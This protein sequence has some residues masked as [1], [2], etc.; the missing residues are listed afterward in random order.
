MKKIVLTGGPCGG[1][2]TALV[3]IKEHFQDK[4]IRVITIPE[5]VTMLSYNGFDIPQLLHNDILKFEETLL[6]T[7]IAIEDNF[8]ELAKIENSPCIIIFDRGAL[9]LKA[10]LDKNTWEI[11]LSTSRYS[12]VYLRDERYDAVIH[13]TTAA[14]GAEDF[15]TLSNNKARTETPEQARVLDTKIIEAWTGQPHLRIIDNSF[16]FEEKMNRVIKEIEIIL[17]DPHPTEYERKFK[18]KQYNIPENI[19]TTSIEITQIYLQTQDKNTEERIR[20]RGQSQNFTY[21]HTKKIDNRNARTEIERQI[22]PNE[23]LHLLELRDKTIPAIIKTRR[24]FVYKSQ[25][26]ELDIFENLSTELAILEI[27]LENENSVFTIPKFIDIEKE[28]T[29]NKQFKNKEIAK[30]L[31]LDM[32]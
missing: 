28:V 1:K 11:L 30:R 31:A 19:P 5:L 25:Y 13:L 23:Y 14:K 16:S 3:K 29:T 18:V 27:E 6:N 24:C 10:Y 8:I 17:G 9:D 2:S 22:S 32:M 4:G 15:Y 21:F 7:Q 20:K 12:E 26:F